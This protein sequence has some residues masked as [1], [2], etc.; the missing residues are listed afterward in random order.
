MRDFLTTALEIIA[1]LLFIAS[2]VGLWFWF[3]P[4]AALVAAVGVVLISRAV[5]R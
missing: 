1:V 3:W 2:V 4:V 5:A